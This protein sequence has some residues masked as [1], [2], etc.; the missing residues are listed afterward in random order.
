MA[1]KTD[2]SADEW[3]LLLESVMLAGV[4][5]TAADPSGLWGTLK[6]GMATASVLRDAKSGTNPLVAAV[7]ADFG[8]PE[9]RRI[10]QDAMNTRLSGS[11][12]PQIKA[13]SVEALRE[14]AMLLDRKAP[15]EAAAFKEWLAQIGSKAAEAS[16]E[17]GFL[18]FGGVSVSESEKATLAEIAGA[19]GTTTP[20]A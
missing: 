4:A 17:G 5:V 10:V 20:T 8:T 15:Q 7:V 1:S 16:K 9:G 13:K 11:Q 3:K 14:A 18:G 19:L 6:E 2:F 12:A